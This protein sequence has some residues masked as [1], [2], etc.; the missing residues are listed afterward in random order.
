MT[1]GHVIRPNEVREIKLFIQK[2]VII[3]I[4]ELILINIKVILKVKIRKGENQTKECKS[5]ELFSVL[6]FSKAMLC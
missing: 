3:F 2:F 1:M 5:G 6:M 4:V